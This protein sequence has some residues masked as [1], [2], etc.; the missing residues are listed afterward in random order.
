MN[1]A[2]IC[3]EHKITLHNVAMREAVVISLINLKLSQKRRN[4]YSDLVFWN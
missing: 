2:E 1:E 3:L 4:L